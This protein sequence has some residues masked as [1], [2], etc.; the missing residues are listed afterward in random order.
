MGIEQI[1]SLPCNTQ[2]STCQNTEH[3]VMGIEQIKWPEQFNGNSFIFNN[4]IFNCDLELYTDSVGG[5]SIGC[6]AYYKN[7]WAYLHWPAEWKCTYF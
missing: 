6:G 3:H 4:W 2:Q 7:K 1:K 5:A